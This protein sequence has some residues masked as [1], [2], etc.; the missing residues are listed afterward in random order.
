MTIHVLLVLLKYKYDHTHLHINDHSAQRRN[1]SDPPTWEALNSGAQMFIQFRKVIFY[2]PG[3]LTNRN[4]SPAGERFF[5]VTSL[6]Q[7]KASMVINQ[8]LCTFRSKAESGH[9]SSAYFF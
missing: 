1:L 9:K 7:D 6:Q 8:V 2:V 3:Q 4:R 5:L